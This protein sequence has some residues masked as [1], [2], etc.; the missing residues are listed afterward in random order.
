MAKE[1]EHLRKIADKINECIAHEFGFNLKVVGWENVI[2]EM[3]DRPQAIINKQIEPYDIFIGIMWKRFGTP[4]GEAESGTEEEFNLAFDCLKKFGTPHIMFYFNQK[5][6]TPNT[7]DD[8]KQMEKVINFRDSMFQEGL[9]WSYNGDEN[10]KDIVDEHLTKLM[11]KLSKKSEEETQKVEKRIMLEPY[12]AHPYPMQENFVGRQK[13]RDLLSEWLENDP[14]PMLALTA[15][16][17]MGKSALSWYWL[18]EDLLKKGKKFDGVFWWS[19]YDEKSSFEKFLDDSIS[20][21]SG[22]KINPKEIRS[23]WDKMQTFFDLF[24][25]SNFFLVL[26]GLERILRA[27]AGMGSPYK[28]DAVKED[29]KQDFRACIDPNAAQFLQRLSAGCPQTKILITSRL[30]PKELEGIAGCRRVNL[31]VMNKEDAVEFFIKQ[32]VKGTRAEIED[33]CCAHGYHPLCLRLLSGMIVKDTKY[34]GDIKAWTRHNPIPELVPKE[35]HI[36]ELAYDSLDDKKRALISKIS[37]FRNPM[38]YNSLLIFND[39]Y[40]EEKFNDVLIELTNRGLLFRDEKHNKFD[41]HPIVRNYCYNRLID[42]KGVHSKLRDYFKEIPEPEKFESVDDLAAVIELYYHTVGAERYD[43]ACDL[44]YDRFGEQLHYRFGAYQTIIELLRA[45]FPDGEDKPPKLKNERYQGWTLNT[46]GSSYSFSGR[47]R[48][49]VSL[50]EMHNKLREKAGDKENIA[51]GLGN[52]SLDQIKLGELDAAESNLKRRIEICREI[53]DEFMEAVS[54]Q[55]LGRLLSYRGNFEE[56]GKELVKAQKVF[57][58]YGPTQTNFV[59]IVLAYR[60]IRSLLMSSADEALT[61]AKKSRE[62]ADINKL[63]R[64]IIQAEYL[65]GAAYIMK[66][67]LTEAEK[68]LTE[69]LTRDRKINLVESEP[70]I[71]LGFAKLRL[72]QGHNDESLKFA[73]EALGIADRCEYRLKQA[74]IHNFLAEFCLDAGDS[75]KAE[76]HGEIAKERASCGYVPALKKAEE[77]LNKIEKI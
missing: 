71:L 65:L 28:G 29:E 38:D 33:V 22:K 14:T 19:F 30:F 55:E 59:S 74:D 62:L 18:N 72:R 32:G 9:A 36:L 17:G 49:A 20:Y 24:K 68:H 73:R 69:A 35:H 51:V 8:L 76:E 21:A 54:N 52:L 3:G 43:E 56:S 26:D 40:S 44:F 53:N 37:A 34:A 2:P 46:L 58:K 66:G 16:G 48:R 7:T 23:T 60:S 12:F 6:F 70:D 5:P 61:S 31:E 27:Y 10:F 47:S 50:R 41:L 39:F 75:E 45:L 11:V 67:N 25:N 63:E 13:E 64:D 4:T 42:K 77:I 15:I 1:R 57:D